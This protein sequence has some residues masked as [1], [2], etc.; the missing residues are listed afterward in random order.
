MKKF[1]NPLYYVTSLV[2]LR[3]LLMIFLPFMATSEPRYALIAKIMNQTNDWITPYIDWGTPFW[4]KPPLSFWLQAISIKVAGPNEFIIRF[5]SLLASLLALFSIFILTK[6]IKNIQAARY[7]CLVF[8]SS[9]L[10][11]TV[12]GA[13]LTDPFLLAGTTLCM[14]SFYMYAAN[15]NKLWEYSFAIGL[16]IGLLA[17]GPLTF[18]LVL[19]PIFLWAF[20]KRHRSPSVNF[21]F[22]LRTI[23]IALT[24]TLPW[25]VAAEI[26][27]P[28]FINY[29][30]I[31]EHL[32]RFLVSGWHGDLYGKAHQY[33]IGSIITWWLVACF[34]WSLVTLILIIKR[35][36]KHLLWRSLK[37]FWQNNTSYLFIWAIFP[38][39]FF[40]FA[41]N[42]LWTYA[43]PGIPAFSIL[44]GSY[45][46]DIQN[47]SRIKASTIIQFSYCLLLITLSCILTRVYM[48]PDTEKYL[49]A[50][51]PKD[52]RVYF[53]SEPSFSAKFYAQS[54][55]KIIKI[56]E[57][58]GLLKIE[59][60]LYI[61]A[62]PDILKQIEN[63]SSYL[64]EEVQNHNKHFHLIKISTR[65]VKMP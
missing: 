3:M 14:T 4:G 64:V 57:I 39:I 30:I 36:Y 40:F 7:A 16:A 21:W 50:K 37:D 43:L 11:F 18:P 38:L 22:W 17:K 42:I 41:R 65:K 20:T 25:Y 13:V 48:S 59:K 46:A 32:Q 15:K 45:L 54:P 53:L 60:P 1:L 52:N 19:G 49:I 56:E 9:V 33:P 29:F 31:G 2:L 58:S 35:L 63:N 8:M 28:G 27:T 12:S 62:P 24:I 5:P 51:L 61:F 10:V 6:Q 47:H 23:L 55:I 26:R 34:P 44:L